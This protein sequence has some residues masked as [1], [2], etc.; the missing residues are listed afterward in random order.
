MKPLPWEAQ[1]KITSE[2]AINNEQENNQAPV[3]E[4][5]RPNKRIKLGFKED[6]FVFFQDNEEVWSSIR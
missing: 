4:K 5:K 3:I 2:Q 6:P 1:L